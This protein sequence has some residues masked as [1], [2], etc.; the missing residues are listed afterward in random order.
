[1]ARIALDRDEPVAL[2]HGA[3]HGM[4]PSSVPSLTSFVEERSKIFGTSRRDAMTG[5][6]D[7]DDRERADARALDRR[8]RCFIDLAVRADDRQPAS[9]G[10]RISGVECEV[11]QNLLERGGIGLDRKRRDGRLGGE[12]DVLADQTSEQ[13]LDH[14]HDLVQVEHL[15]RHHLLAAEG[16]QLLRQGC[17]LLARGLDLREIQAHRVRIAQMTS[18]QARVPQD[19]RQKIVEVVGDAACKPSGPPPSF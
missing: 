17:R 15:R 2:L 7:R 10:H 12:I 3:D 19:R 13:F 8:R 4:S 16:E 9:V 5:V 11:D 1:M 18:G 14:E 6:G